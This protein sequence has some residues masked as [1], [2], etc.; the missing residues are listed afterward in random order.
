M[1]NVVFVAFFFAFFFLGRFTFATSLGTVTLVVAVVDVLDAL[2]LFLDAVDVSTMDLFGGRLL[3]LADFI[4]ALVIFLCFGFIDA[5]GSSSDLK[6]VNPSILIKRS[7]FLSRV[8]VHMGDGIF[9]GSVNIYNG[10]GSWWSIST[11]L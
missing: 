5:M 10:G 7:M 1:G 4:F 2:W 6:S 3:I 9:C 8:V 11:L